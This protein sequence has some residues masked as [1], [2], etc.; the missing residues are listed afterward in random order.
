MDLFSNNPMLLFLAVF[1]ALALIGLLVFATSFTLGGESGFSPILRAKKPP[2]LKSLPKVDSLNLPPPPRHLEFWGVQVRVVLDFLVDIEGKASDLK[3]LETSHPEL[4][5]G[6]RKSVESGKF[7][8][9]V[10]REGESVEFRM[11]L[12][13]FTCRGRPMERRPQPRTG[14]GALRPKVRN[15]L[16]SDARKRRREKVSSK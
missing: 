2:E 7:I 5:H 8:P 1:G 13:I 6:F 3:V 4:V 10:N 15:K 12:P 9:A 14:P 16:T 11:Q